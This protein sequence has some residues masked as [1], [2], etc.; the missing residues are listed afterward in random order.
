MVAAIIGGCQQSVVRCFTTMRRQL[1]RH[2]CNEPNRRRKPSKQHRFHWNTS[3][4]HNSSNLDA[5]WMLA[6]IISASTNETRWKLL[7]Q[8]GFPWTQFTRLGPL[9]IACIMHDH[10]CHHPHPHQLHSSRHE[11]SAVYPIA[12]GG[13]SVLHWPPGNKTERSFVCI[14]LWEYFLALNNEFANFGFSKQCP[15]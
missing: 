4:L 6:R 14:L 7:K 2:R 9:W 13:K 15:H 1:A 10:F 12:L 5:A 8:I 11:R 3:L